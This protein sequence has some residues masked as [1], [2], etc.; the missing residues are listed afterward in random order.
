MIDNSNESYKEMSERVVERLSKV[1]T[2]KYIEVSPTYSGIAKNIS[3][4]HSYDDY[5]SFPN[6]DYWL[7]EKLLAQVRKV[8][9]SSLLVL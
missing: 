4:R 3:I 7:P 2:I 9:T 6:D 5:V 1:L 8:T